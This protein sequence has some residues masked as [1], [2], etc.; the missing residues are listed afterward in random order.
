MGASSL[1]RRKRTRRSRSWPWPQERQITWP[2]AFEEPS[3]DLWTEMNW[4]KM[5]PQMNTDEHRSVF[6]RVHLWFHSVLFISLLALASTFAIPEKQS[7]PRW[8][9]YRKHLLDSGANE[10]AAVAKQGW[11]TGHHR[12]REL[13]R[14]ASV[15]KAPHARDPL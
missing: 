6:I 9:M 5:K 13:V 14:S 15:E 3:S 10:S 12:G 2:S 7:A 11:K 8:P 4:T 1:P